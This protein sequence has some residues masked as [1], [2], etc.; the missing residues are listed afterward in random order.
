MSLLSVTRFLNGFL[1]VAIPIGLGVYL[2]R[3]FQMG[4]RLWW[5]GAATFVMSQVGHLPFNW[6]LNRLFVLGMLPSPPAS[7]RLYFFA[8]LGGLSAGLWEELVRAG[9]FKWWAVDARTWRKGVMLGAGHGGI[10]AIILGG[11]VLIGFVNILILSGPDA[12]RLVPPNQ[13]A[14]VQ[15]QIAAYWSGSPLVALMGA[16][17]RIF[18]ITN[19]IALSL[20]VMQAFTRRQPA[21]IALAVIYH[22]LLDGSMAYLAGIWGQ[23]SWGVLAIE[24]AIGIGALVSLGII[25]A[26]YQ[27]EPV[28]KPDEVET[29]LA[30][31]SLP[32]VRIADIL[33]E[34]G[35][36]DIS[37]D[38]LAKSRYSQ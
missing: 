29:L 11:L 25:F 17:E 35:D 19:H 15:Q 7:W 5:I 30:S 10:E 26:L 1:M 9:V 20:M 27:P 3:R 31:E 38:T 13:L 22:T 6:I 28:E 33:I 24:G 8:I 2:T 12:A 18:A 14:L 21:W 34:Q 16:V 36:K 32:P 4:W 23:Q 37:E